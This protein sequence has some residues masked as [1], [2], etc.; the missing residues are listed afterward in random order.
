MVNRPLGALVGGERIKRTTRLSV[1]LQKLTPQSGHDAREKPIFL[2][3]V[4]G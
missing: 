4:V 3:V 1:C 2:R